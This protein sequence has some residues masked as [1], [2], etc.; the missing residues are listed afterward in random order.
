[1]SDDENIDYLGKPWPV[2]LIDKKISAEEKEV[3]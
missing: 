3:F 1:M 2:R